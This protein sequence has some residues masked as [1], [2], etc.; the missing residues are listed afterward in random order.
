MISTIILTKNEE[1][2]IVDCLESLGWCDE[3]IVVDDDS[4]DRTIELAQRFKVKIFKRKLDNDFSA[5]RNFAISKAKNDW[6]LFLD[7]D[8]RIPDLLA[9]EIIEKTKEQGVDAY[10][11]ERI[12]VMWGKVLMHGE[13]GNIKLLRLAR[14]GKGNWAN[15]VHEKWVIRGNTS[16]LK[17]VF[18]HYPHQKLSEFLREINYY[19][20]VRSEELFNMK[21]KTSWLE[22]IFYPL[23]KF[24]VNFFLKLGFLD[25]TRGLVLATVMSFHSFLV[26]S[27][28][29][30]L[31]QK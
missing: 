8:E 15:K 28:L 10:Y 6:V 22:I 17:N 21:I 18:Y 19:T 11:I 23:G 1:K 16:V 26:R 13:T 29:W 24:I 7:A 9:I 4:D 25:G 31:W 2:N 5:Q 3:V 27:K 30:F 12:D 20:D 14:K